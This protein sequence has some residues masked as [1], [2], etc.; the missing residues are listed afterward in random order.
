M[1]VG[2][3]R[4][5]WKIWSH[6]K[7][8]RCGAMETIQHVISCPA[9]EAREVWA[10]VIKGLRE[11]MESVRS[12]TQ[13]IESLVG[14]VC[15]NPPT[16][17]EVGHD[18]SLHVAML[19]QAVIGFELIVEGWLAIE[20]EGAQKSYFKLLNSHK[21][22][23]R[24]M[25]CLLQRLWQIVWDMWE[26]RNEVL[27]HQQNQATNVN[28]RDLDKA[29]KRLYDQAIFRLP[30]TLD[31][32]LTKKSLRTILRLPRECKMKCAKAMNIA[33]T[34]IKNKQEKERRDRTSM[35]RRLY[36]WLSGQIESLCSL[37][38]A[39]LKR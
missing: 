8:P 34:H 20:W 27:H 3:F 33:L 17:A 16:P 29:I 1:G 4:K 10:K 15:N 28:T 5:R 18:P 35:C 31:R 22:G 6:D 11:W 32:Y 9:P 19:Q 21:S 7:C 38:Q 2:R 39:T 23:Q 26:H 13:I 24:W 25:I 12:N 37:L 14:A 36:R 30:H